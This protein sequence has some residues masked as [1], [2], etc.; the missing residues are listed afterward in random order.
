MHITVFGATGKTGRLVVEQGL[1]AGHRVTAVVRSSARFTADS[2]ARPGLEVVE[3][4]SFDDPEAV[5]ESLVD[6]LVFT[7]AAISAVGPASRKDG[8][9]AAPVTRG[10]LA[11]LDRAKVRRLVTISAA[12]VSTPATG[13]EDGFLDRRIVYPLISALLKPVYDDLRAMEQELSASS[14]DWTAARPPRLTDGAHTRNYRTR[15]DGNVPRGRLL[16][17]ADLADFL[18]AA[19]GDHASAGHA[20]G[21]AY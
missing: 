16:S 13:P 10:I 19:A 11:A 17:R 18:L 20:V 15:L 2:G 4:A 1:S 9:V 14:V 8:P 12:P 21:V 3:Q 7:D 6:H 5:A